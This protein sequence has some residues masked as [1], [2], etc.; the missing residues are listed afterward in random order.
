MNELEIKKNITKDYVE[1]ILCGR[2]NTSTAPE[3]EEFFLDNVSD[4]VLQLQIELSAVE[5]VS[6]A[7][8]RI[9]LKEHKKIKKQGGEMTLKGV[10]QEVMDVFDSTG[11][12]RL[13][14]IERA[15]EK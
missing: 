15:K 3:L 8:L 10:N 13:L 7:G 4:E 2:V 5:Y 14:H 9:F 12:T 6:S 1:I 11:F